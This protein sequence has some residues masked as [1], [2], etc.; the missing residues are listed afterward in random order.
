VTTIIDVCDPDGT[1]AV[2]THFMNMSATPRHSLIRFPSERTGRPARGGASAGEILSSRI[3]RWFGR[4]L[5]LVK[6]PGAIQS[7]EIDDSVAGHHIAV[8]VGDLFIRLSVNGRDYYFNRLTGRFD[9]T[10]MQPR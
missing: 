9:G 6:I 1:L 8:M 4:A 2:V 5:N 7:V 3:R 10:G